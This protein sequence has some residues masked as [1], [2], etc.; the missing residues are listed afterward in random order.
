LA[1]LNGSL[2]SNNWIQNFWKRPNARGEQK[3]EDGKVD[4]EENATTALVA[5]RSIKRLFT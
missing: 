4:D 1:I 3:E 5:E 2:N